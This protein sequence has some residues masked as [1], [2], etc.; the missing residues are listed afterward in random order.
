MAKKLR[1]WQ[2]ICVQCEMEDIRG[3]SIQQIADYSPYEP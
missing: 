1:E 2:E 3:I